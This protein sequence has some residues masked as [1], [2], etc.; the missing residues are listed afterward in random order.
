VV[1]AA[2]QRAHE[3]AQVRAVVLENHGT[4]QERAWRIT[5]RAQE[6]VNR[7]W[8]RRAEQAQRGQAPPQCSPLPATAAEAWAALQREG[9]SADAVRSYLAPGPEPRYDTPEARAAASADREAGS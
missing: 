3:L 7:A 9:S 4:E 2:E 8:D 1:R 5:D 6:A